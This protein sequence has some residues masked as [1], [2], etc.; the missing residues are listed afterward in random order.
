MLGLSLQNTTRALSF[1]A[2]IV[3][4]QGAAI[5]LAGVSWRSQGGRGTGRVNRALEGC[6][7]QLDAIAC[8][9][10]GRCALVSL[11]GCILD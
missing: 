3:Q 5:F 9:A 4:G 2:R 10:L 11:G 7:G 1:E 6:T 8:G